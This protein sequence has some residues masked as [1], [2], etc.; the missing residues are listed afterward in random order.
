MPATQLVLL[1]NDRRYTER[2]APARNETAAE[3]ASAKQVAGKGDLIDVV[4]AMGEWVDETNAAT[5][6]AAH[7]RRR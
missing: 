7:A 2:P 5:T 6:S 3:T 4:T 1:K